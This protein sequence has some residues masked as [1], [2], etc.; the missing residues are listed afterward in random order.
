VLAPDLAA[1]GDTRERFEREGRAISSLDH[2]HICALYDI[3]REGPI[4]FLVMQYLEGGRPPRARRAFER[5]PLRAQS[6]ER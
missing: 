5:R 2:P 4:D 3:G 1:R 6:P